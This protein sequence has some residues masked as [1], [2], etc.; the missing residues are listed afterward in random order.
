M[1]CRECNVFLQDSGKRGRASCNAHFTLTW[2][3]LILN[4]FFFAIP[5]SL[6]LMEMQLY[7]TNGKYR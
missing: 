3:I 5:L 6:N 2:I 4:L 7:M 1:E